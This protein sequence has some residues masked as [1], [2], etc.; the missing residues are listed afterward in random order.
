MKKILIITLITAITLIN[1]V[2][3]QVSISPVTIS[4]VTISSVS[5]SPVYINPVT[6]SRP[7][8]TFSSYNPVVIIRN[9]NIYQS[10]ISQVNIKNPQVV[11]RVYI[12]HYDPY[13]LLKD[14]YQK[15][16]ISYFDNNLNN[17]VY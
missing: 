17:F 2:F 15:I 11:N 3:A 10:S 13:K 16:R 6:I 12:N 5:V 1:F 7:S 8:V 14:S 4:S 9:V